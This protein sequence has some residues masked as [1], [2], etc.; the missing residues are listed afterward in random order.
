MTAIGFAEALS[1]CLGAAKELMYDLAEFLV[2][3]YPEIY[4]VAR[5][6]TQLGDFG[7]Y[8]EGQ[9]HTITIKP[10]GITYDLD[11]ED[12]MTMAALM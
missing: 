5:H 2:R 8:G 6:D 1:I 9:I 7:W 10:L 3:R 4:S 12:P 11:K